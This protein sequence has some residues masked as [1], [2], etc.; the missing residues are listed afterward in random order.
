MAGDAILAAT[1]AEVRR[2]L[3]DELASVRVARAVVGLF[4]TG[5]KLESGP[6]GL[7]ATPRQA[8]R[9][10]VCCPNAGGAVPFAGRL[11]GTPAAELLAEALHP[12]SLRRALGIATL[13]ALAELALARFENPPWSTRADT[14]AFDAV[15]IA[16]DDRV[17]LV[18]AF[19]PFIKAL[20]ERGQP[21]IVVEKDPKTLRPEEMRF[22]RPAAEAPSVIREADVALVTGTTL[23]DGAIDAIAAALRP[24]VRAALVGPSVPRWPG[25][26][27]AAGFSVV[28]TLTVS[29]PDPLLDL[30]AEGGGAPQFLGRFAR[31]LCL[32]RPELASS[33]R[34]A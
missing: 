31:K 29:D 3:G 32:I 25:P 6:S 4:Y 16:Q 33:R 14:D 18:G 7:C 8:I 1:V 11:A 20:K 19:G 17:V 12:S 34:A 15:A 26:F 10:A 5:V 27:F 23:L 30:L 9:D 2:T 28:G 22:F 13:N 21:F 24:G